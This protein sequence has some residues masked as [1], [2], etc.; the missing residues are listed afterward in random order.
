VLPQPSCK[1]R[2]ARTLAGN[3][4]ASVKRGR[5]LLSK[6][7]QA[8][9]LYSTANLVYLPTGELIP[10]TIEDAGTGIMDQPLDPKS[11]GPGDAGSASSFP[12]DPTKRVI[13]IF[14]TDLPFRVYFWV[15]SPVLI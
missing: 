7:P 3:G 14:S 2:N 9:S 5:P 4:F 8:A 6:K 1:E 10:E 12:V 15:L 13:D 11:A